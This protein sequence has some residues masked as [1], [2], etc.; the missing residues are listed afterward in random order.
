VKLTLP[1]KWNVGGSGVQ[2]GAK[3][4]GNGTQ[5]VSFHAED[6]HDFAWT[7]DPTTKVVEDSI[8]LSGGTVKIRMLMQPGHMGSAGRYMDALKGTMRK[9]DEWIGPYPYP[10]I[11]VV[12]PPHGGSG[13]GGMEYPTLIT[14]D[15]SWWVPKALLEP[16]AVVEHEFG[17]QYWYGMVATNEFENAWMDEGINQ[18]TE[19]KIMDALYGKNTS[20][21]NSR[22]AT[23]GERGTDRASY[24]P[25]ADR[26]PLSR[27]A[28]LYV[29]GSSYGATT[30]S[31]TALMMLTLENLIGEKNVLHGL[32]V[33]FDRYKFKHP[34]PGEFTSTMNEAVG[35]NLDWYW[36]QAIYGT[37]TLDDRILSAGSERL[38]WYNKA[39]EKKGVTVYHSEVT[40]HRRGT[41][42]LPVVL[43]AKFDDGSTV[44]ERWD[45]KD[46]WHRFTWDSKAKLVSAEID[47]DHGNLLDR[48][49]FNNSWTE[50]T[51]RR[52]TGKLAGY[53][54][55]LTQ[56]MAQMLSWLA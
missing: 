11:T 33:Y 3:D 46:R 4:N 9:F 50:K 35:Q 44:L 19:A 18:Y 8:K 20:N 31:K 26:D 6:V 56:W 34:T 41:F 37:E 17:H 28:W 49:P 51:D 12:D 47:P 23:I 21:I 48:D 10:Q 36:K 27:P 24:V 52:A 45:G 1:A 16:E 29:D 30:Y 14:A 15:T 2:T 7:A 54:T 55:L 32:H 53:F 39:D 40:V 25:T 5:T 42:D 38:D 13:A 43:E 22:I